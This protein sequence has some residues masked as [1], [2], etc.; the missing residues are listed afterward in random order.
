MDVIDL[1]PRLERLDS[2]ALSDALDAIGH[3]GVVTGI[4]R[5]STRQ[6]VAGR[7]RTMRIAAGHPPGGSTVHLGVRSIDEAEDTDVIVIEQKS[8]I[9]AATWGGVL[10]EAAHHK[11]IRGVVIDG[12]VR[13]VDEINETGLPVFARSVTPISARGRIHEEAINVPVSIGDVTVN[14]GD[15]VFADGTGVVFLAQ[16]L[17]EE[18]IA[19]AEAIADKER[20][21]VEAVHEHKPV[22]EVMGKDYETMLGTQD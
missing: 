1:L 10:S 11:H 22:T 4:V 2:C 15:L 21:M 17:A 8:G 6:S 7:V 13:D 16:N 3:A 5:Q 20:R 9:D 19:K 14:P 18:I 12:A